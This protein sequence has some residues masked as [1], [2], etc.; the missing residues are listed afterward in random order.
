MSF[1]PTTFP[2]MFFY[3]HATLEIHAAGDGLH[4]TLDDLNK[5]FPESSTVKGLRA[6]VHY[7]I[8]GQSQ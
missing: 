5:I 4:E 7:H 8:R 3:V 1:I 2:A 6:L